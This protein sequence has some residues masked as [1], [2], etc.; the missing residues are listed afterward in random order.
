MTRDV[1]AG[2]SFN[3][4]NEENDTILSWSKLR[5]NKCFIILIENRTSG[6][7]NERGHF[8]QEIKRNYESNIDFE[9]KQWRIIFFV[10]HIK[11][12]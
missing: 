12:Y 4:F 5:A 2:M 3:V 9:K 1:G 11:K 8:Y 6:E 10:K 7:E